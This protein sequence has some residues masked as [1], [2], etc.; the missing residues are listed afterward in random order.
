MAHCAGSECGRWRPD[1]LVG[2]VGVGL[3][4]EGEWYCSEACLEA[5]AT[6]R[7]EIA[8]SGEAP[9]IPGFP[10]SRLGTVLLSRQVLTR[11][12][13]SA[14]LVEQRRR[15]WRLGRTLT[16]LGLVS[17]LDVLRALA[18]QAGVDYL[19]AI[20]ESHVARG[21]GN[22]GP[23]AVRLLGLVPFEV[24]EARRRMKV[25]CVA[26]L[27]RKAL[28]AVRAI[29]SWTVDAFLVTDEQWE[30]LA[31][32]YGR[33]R[34]AADPAEEEAGELVGSVPEAAAHIARRVARGQVQRMQYARCAPYVWIRLEGPRTE[35]L[36]L[37]LGGARTKESRWPVVPMS[38]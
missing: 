8:T 13:L 6:A 7:L 15:G 30:R 16:G 37:P 11:T 28:A 20:D 10:R 22:F 23:R 24:D 35:D 9:T 19:S 25:A 26:P 18:A 4:F 21:P 27:P 38:H 12:Q 3:R 29:T 5:E 32:A 33:D 2:S 31:S 14:G 34:R 1:V 36:V 17:G